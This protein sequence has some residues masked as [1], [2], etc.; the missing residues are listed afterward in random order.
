METILCSLALG[1]TDIYHFCFY[2]FCTREYDIFYTKFC[3]TM[4]STLGILYILTQ[5]CALP[6]FASPEDLI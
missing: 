5:D 3:K 2:I 4:F 1:F 6:D